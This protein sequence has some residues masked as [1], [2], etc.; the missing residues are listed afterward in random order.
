MFL[1]YAALYLSVIASPITGFPFY[2]QQ[3]SGK[4]GLH[5]MWETFDSF[6]FHGVVTD[7]RAKWVTVGG[8]LSRLAHRPA[9]EVQCASR[10]FMFPSK[11]SG[12]NHHMDHLCSTACKLNK[13]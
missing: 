9:V 12:R 3:G 4:L 11:A 10:C 5:N 7:E 8:S 13:I 6:Q 2:L 1:C